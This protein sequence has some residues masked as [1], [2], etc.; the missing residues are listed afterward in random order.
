[1]LFCY[2]WFRNWSVKRYSATKKSTP[3]KPL[4]TR[5]PDFD[6]L[7]FREKLENVFQQL[8]GSKFSEGLPKNEANFK[9]VL[10]FLC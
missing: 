7:K 4:L 6:S 2:L 5:Y 8:G 1:M 10:M 3:C 9:E